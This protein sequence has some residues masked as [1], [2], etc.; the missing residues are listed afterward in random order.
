MEVGG[1]VGRAAPSGRCS[2]VGGGGYNYA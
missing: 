1:R 2:I